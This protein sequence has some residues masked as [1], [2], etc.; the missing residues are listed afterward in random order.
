MKSNNS[1]NGNGIDKKRKIKSCKIELFVNFIVLGKDL[2]DERWK[3]YTLVVEE[4]GTEELIREGK[5]WL[6]QSTKRMKLL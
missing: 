3:F 2:V 5:T 6:S 1:K 4:Y